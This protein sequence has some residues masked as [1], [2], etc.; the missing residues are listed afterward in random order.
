[1]KKILLIVGAAFLLGGFSSCD[2]CTTCRIERLNG[3][4]EAEYEEYCGTP[5]EI[6]DFKNDLENKTNAQ[7]GSNG[8]VIC[9]DN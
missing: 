9:V 2:K 4:V 5:K 1:M 8:I 7:L 6:E 3:V